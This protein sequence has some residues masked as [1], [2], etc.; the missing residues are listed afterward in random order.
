[1]SDVADV[2][3]TSCVHV[4]LI[5]SMCVLKRHL[6]RLLVVSRSRN[7]ELIRVLASQKESDL[8][9]RSLSDERISIARLRL[10]IEQI[11][12][13]LEVASRLT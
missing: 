1:M 10:V 9:K 13:R 8:H 2:R 7:D 4:E 5:R 6:N 11:I 12:K 3:Q